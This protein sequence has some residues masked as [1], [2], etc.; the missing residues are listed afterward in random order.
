[1]CGMQPVIKAGRVPELYCGLCEYIS[2]KLWIICRSGRWGADVKAGYWDTA[3]V[4]FVEEGVDETMGYVLFLFR[5]AKEHVI[6]LP[7]PCIQIAE[8]FVK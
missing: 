3:K 4:R 7:P 8:I 2:E 5:R 6:P 1:M